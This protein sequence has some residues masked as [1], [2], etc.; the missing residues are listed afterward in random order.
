MTPRSGIAS[1]AQAAEM[2]ELA[3]N[4]KGRRATMAANWGLWQPNLTVQAMGFVAVF[5][6]AAIG[7]AKDLPKGPYA[8][9]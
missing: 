4:A 6:L 2:H 8:F 7:S 3:A 1:R 5:Y 9:P